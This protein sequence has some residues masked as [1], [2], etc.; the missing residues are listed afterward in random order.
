MRED[1]HSDCIARHGAGWTGDRHTVRSLQHLRLETG[2]GIR[3]FVGAFADR[4]LS[5][6]TIDVALWCGAGRGR[7]VKAGLCP[8]V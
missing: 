1:W 6:W 8:F 7:R 4:R 3:R 2:I 5:G